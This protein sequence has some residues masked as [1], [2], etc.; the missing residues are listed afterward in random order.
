[1][2]K[3]AFTALLTFC[4]T[5][6][7]FSGYNPLIDIEYSLSTFSKTRQTASAER[8]LCVFL[9]TKKFGFFKHLRGGEGLE[10]VHG[11]GSIG[12]DDVPMG[13]AEKKNELDQDDEYTPEEPSVQECFWEA[14]KAGEENTIEKLVQDGADVNAHDASF[15]GWTAMHYAAQNGRWRAISALVKLG[16][17]VSIR[18]HS[19]K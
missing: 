9:Q 6:T 18:R 15:G 16:A 17:R 2:S 14:A 5:T 4:S 10:E 13:D 3:F 7:L 1:M 12:N 19:S 11:E 8:N